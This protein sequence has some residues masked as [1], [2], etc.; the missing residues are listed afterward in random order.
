MLARQG[1]VMEWVR[2]TEDIEFKLKAFLGQN[3]KA[4]D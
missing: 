1:G 4:A 2:S 3:W